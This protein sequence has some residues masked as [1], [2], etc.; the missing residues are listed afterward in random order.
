[1]TRKEFTREAA[2]A[3]GERIG[4]D[5]QA[6]D[7]D[8]EQ[9]RMGLAVELEDGTIDPSTDVTHDDEVIFSGRSRSLTCTRSRTT[10]R[11]W[12]RWSETRS[13]RRPRR[14]H[15][16]LEGGIGASKL[17]RPRIRRSP[18]VPDPTSRF[19]PS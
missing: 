17:L 10:T 12:P 13:A 19:S 9:F 16:G 8:L 15:I 1:M 11:G 5:W 4:I 2:K 18:R 3:I 7:I 14:E 6:G